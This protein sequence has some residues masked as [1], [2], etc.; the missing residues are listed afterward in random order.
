MFAP[1]PHSEPQSGAAEDLMVRVE[2]VLADWQ[3]AVGHAGVARALSAAQPALSSLDAARLLQVTLHVQ[4]LAC[5][6][7]A[8]GAPAASAWDP[9]SGGSSLLPLHW[10]PAAYL[11]AAALHFVAPAASATLHTAGEAA[12]FEA[13]AEAVLAAGRS[14][15]GLLTFVR[16]AAASPL[17]VLDGSAATA[18]SS[19]HAT[20]FGGSDVAAAL[21]WRALPLQQGALS[22]WADALRASPAVHSELRLRGVLLGV[23]W[24]VGAAAAPPPQRVALDAEGALLVLSGE[25]EGG[26]GDGGEG[27]SVLVWEAEGA[28]ATAGA[29]G[30]WLD[31]RRLGTHGVPRSG[32]VE[33]DPAAADQAEAVGDRGGLDGWEAAGAVP[34]LVALRLASGAHHQRPGT[35]YLCSHVD[36]QRLAGGVPFGALLC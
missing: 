25:E 15:Q 3:G 27:G 20:P 31:V 24:K 36:F 32:S 35:A 12:D 2:A 19:L 13:D 6:P 5:S 16:V 22:G 33:A 17:C 34:R 11:A 4:V 26:G 7:F 18:A 28:G 23:L 10:A 1:P 9:G 29:A 8:A 30:L 21:S 14:A